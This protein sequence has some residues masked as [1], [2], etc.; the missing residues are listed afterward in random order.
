[1]SAPLSALLAGGLF[2]RLLATRVVSQS[3]DGLFQIATASVLLFENPGPNPV[4]DL[5]AISAIT[6]IPFSILGPFAGVFIDRWDRRS[7]LI[8]VPLLRAAAAVAIAATSEGSVAFYGLALIVLSANRFFLATISAE[9]PLSV[10]ADSLLK[11]NAVQTTGGAIANVLGQGGGALIAGAIGGVRTAIIA[12]LAFAAVTPITRG[13]PKHRG[14]DSGPKARFGTDVAR[15]TR[16]TIEGASAVWRDA[17]VRRA[18]T[19]I[20][21]VQVGVGAMIGVMIHTFIT[22]L[23]L[24]VDESFAVLAVLALGI[25]VGVVAVPAIA[26]RISPDVMIGVSFAGAAI[27]TAGTAFSL[28]KGAMIIAAGVVGFSYAL[29]KIPV[30]TI[31]QEEIPDAERGRAFALYDVLFNVA[32]VAGIALAA[33]AFEARMGAGAIALT[34]AAAFALTGVWLHVWGTRLRARGIPGPPVPSA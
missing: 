11:A 7:I 18:L 8:V 33:L 17:R 20:T 34:T 3:G 31:V 24:D 1:M 28:T 25:G 9:L 27:A 16:E 10:P 26:H 23:K 22:V 6:L 15:V 19:A 29:V 5:L 32:R 2:R 12:A 21:L 30:D 13:V 4:V 14:H